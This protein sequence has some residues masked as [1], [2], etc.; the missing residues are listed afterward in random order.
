MA[1]INIPFKVGNQLGGEDRPFDNHELRLKAAVEL[2]TLQ[3]IANALES[4]NTTL[5]N[6]NTQKSK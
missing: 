5:A 3:R 4:L 6:S 1:K 2:E